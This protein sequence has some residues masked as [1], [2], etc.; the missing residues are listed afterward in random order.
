MIQKKK[1]RHHYLA[2]RLNRKRR[3][4]WNKSEWKLGQVFQ[5]GV[6]ILNWECSDITLWESANIYPL[7]NKEHR[8]QR[9]WREAVSSHHLWM[10]TK[11]NQA[12]RIPIWPFLF[13]FSKRWTTEVDVNGLFSQ[14]HD[15]MDNFKEI[16]QRRCFNTGLLDPHLH[17]DSTELALE[18]PRLW[19]RST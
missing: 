14:P 6:G 13:R 1:K 8:R 15:C 18:K 7:A 10:H 9:R 5:R 2:M 3:A 19:T 16:W 17:Q 4:S 11:S 12:F